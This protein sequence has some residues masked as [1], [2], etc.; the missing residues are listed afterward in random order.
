MRKFMSA[1][2]AG[3][4]LVV[5]KC[6]CLAALAVKA[7]TSVSEAG[8]TIYNFDSGSLASSFTQVGSAGN[9][10]LNGS[11]G[12]NGTGAISVAAGSNADLLLAK[13]PLSAMNSGD[14][15]KLSGFWLYDSSRRDPFNTQTAISIGLAPS[16]TSSRLV[17]DVTINNRSGGLSSFMNYHY[18]TTAGS[19]TA[20]TGPS[21]ANLV[22]GNWY[23]LEY[24]VTAIGG[25]FNQF[26]LSYVMTE[27]GT[28]GSTPGRIMS[29]GS[30]SIGSAYLASLPS[31]YAGFSAEGDSGTTTI[32][33]F[34]VTAV[35]E[36]SALVLGCVGVAGTWLAGCRRKASKS[37]GMTQTR[38]AA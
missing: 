16:L 36:P 25:A 11:G 38:T 20:A 15:I 17:Y 22:T 31:L 14:S 34:Q 24:S 8:T 18:A 28:S 30:T 9:L 21:V 12:L 1:N 32:D 4:Y 23:R 19:S 35:P 5:L 7:S 3:W 10:Q 2:R 37:F 27:Y 33:Y 13:T 26:D 29:S 6:A